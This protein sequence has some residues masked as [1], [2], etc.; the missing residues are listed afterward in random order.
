M[1]D[2]FGGMRKETNVVYFKAYYSE[3]QTKI[4]KELHQDSRNPS[5]D[6]N[7]APAEQYLRQ[8]AQ[9]HTAFKH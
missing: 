5:V 9:S 3:G 7:R 6:S 8:P 2:E 4:L 1:I